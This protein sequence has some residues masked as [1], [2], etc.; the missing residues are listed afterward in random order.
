MRARL[1]S[2]AFHWL[3]GLVVSLRQANLAP[4]LVPAKKLPFF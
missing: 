3:R 1:Y 2:V 4:V